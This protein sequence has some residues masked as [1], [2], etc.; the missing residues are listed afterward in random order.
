MQRTFER[1]GYLQHAV[2]FFFVF[3]GAAV[4]FAQLPTATILGTVTDAT[5]AVIP[6]VNLT[7][8]NVDTGQTRATVSGLDGSYR[9]SA[10]PIGSY[11]VQVT[12]AGFQSAVRSGLR[13]SVG[14]EATRRQY[15]GGTS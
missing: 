14:Q 3:L 13:L 9:F 7:A 11:E 5:G 1:A 8:R 10:L 15:R 12:Q 2:I 4:S 6:Q